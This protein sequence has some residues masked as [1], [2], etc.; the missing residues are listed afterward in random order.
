MNRL[1]YL[2]THLISCIIKTCARLFTTV[3]KGQIIGISPIQCKIVEDMQNGLEDNFLVKLINR[4]SQYT[5]VPFIL[6]V[7]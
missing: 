5:K 4:R 2:Y 1:S 3:F 7:S 6:Y